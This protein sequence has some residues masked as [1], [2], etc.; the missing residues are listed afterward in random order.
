VQRFVP[1]RMLEQELPG[2]LS[3]GLVRQAVSVQRSDQRY[4]VPGAPLGMR[5]DE[6]ERILPLVRTPAG[7]RDDR[8]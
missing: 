4:L 2:D 3:V 1:L 7:N 6:R 8:L 5:A